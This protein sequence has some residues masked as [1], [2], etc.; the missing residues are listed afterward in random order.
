VAIYHL[1]AS[2]LVG[3]RAA[4]QFLTQEGAVAERIV[5]SGGRERW[6]CGHLIDGASFGGRSAEQ[7]LDVTDLHLLRIPITQRRYAHSCDGTSGTSVNLAGDLDAASPPT[8]QVRKGERVVRALPAR[9]TSTSGPTWRWSVDH[10]PRLGPEEGLALVVRAGGR[11]NTSVVPTRHGSRRRVTRLRKAVRIGWAELT[12]VLAM[13][14]GR[15]LPRRD[16]IVLESHGGA[17]CTGSVLAIAENLRRRHPDI[18]QVWSCLPGAADPPSY[19]RRVTRVSWSHAWSTMRARWC[20]DD[21]T[22]PLDIRVR[23]AAVMV[24]P[25]TPVH[26]QGLDDPSVLTSPVAQQQVV[27]RSRR[28]RAILAASRRDAEVARRA[29]SFAG[30]VVAVGIPRLDPVL[31]AD[32]RARAVAEADVP[33]D[34]VVVTYVPE[35]RARV[36]F[37]PTAW[38]SAMGQATYLLVVG[39]PV[40]ADL[41]WAARAVP[42]HA[43]VT[44]LLAASDMVISDYSSFIGDAAALGL[45][46]VPFATSVELC[47][48]AV[49]DAFGGTVSGIRAASGHRWLALD[50]GN[51]K[52]EIVVEQIAKLPSVNIH[53]MYIYMRHT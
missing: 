53:M 49:R 9:W 45:P 40:P 41:A 14:L 22:M 43:E 51:L 20:L 37:D 21:G 44:S 32:A 28:L 38:V 15:W 36:P 7:W 2:D 50:H 26:H 3:I 52:I 29:W 11:T 5:E 30:D 33:S 19:A 18:R 35:P 39:V 42:A 24:T 4:M 46:V 6:A 1:L 34:R 31:R 17:S 47:A 10:A 48:Q 8:L 25:G 23:G 27:R 13:V 12:A 16:L